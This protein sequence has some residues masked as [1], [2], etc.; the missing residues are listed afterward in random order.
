MDELK[1]KIPSVVVAA[2]LNGCLAVQDWAE[3]LADDGGF[4]ANMVLRN[5]LVWS[6]IPLC[7]KKLRVPLIGKIT[8]MND[9]VLLDTCRNLTALKQSRLLAFDYSPSISK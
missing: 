8:S 1:K 7:L 6:K 3:N 9:K 4:W 5:P 2:D